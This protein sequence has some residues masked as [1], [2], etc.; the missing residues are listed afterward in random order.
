MRLAA[1]LLDLDDLVVDLGVAAG[2]ESAAV[3]HHVDLVRAPLHD[4]SHLGE[5]DLERGLPGRE[6]GRDGSDADARAPKAGDGGRDEVR[7]DAH[8]G[9][10]R[11]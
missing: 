8:G 4:L 2:E 5:L 9:D 11:D 3:D 1:G 7:V 6:G 10:G